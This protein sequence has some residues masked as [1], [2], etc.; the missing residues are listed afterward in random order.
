M[1]SLDHCSAPV[2]R[3]PN[4]LTYNIHAFS[5]SRTTFFA[6]QVERYA[7]LY[8]SSCYNLVYYPCF[9]FFRAPM[10]LMPH[11]STVD[12]SSTIRPRGE[13]QHQASVG[14]Q[15]RGWNKRMSKST[16]FCFEE[17]DDTESTNSDSERK[18]SSRLETAVADVAADDG[19]ENDALNNTDVLVPNPSYVEE[20]HH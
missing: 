15:V 8:A 16:T 6:S 7:D 5:G 19:A 14:Q 17:E 13:L 1:E 20:E 2:F 10:T 11:E 4:H 12:H 9:Y 3:F 18:N